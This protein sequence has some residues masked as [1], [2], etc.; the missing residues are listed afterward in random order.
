MSPL[1]GRVLILQALPI[2]QAAL[3]NEHEILSAFLANSYQWSSK[4]GTTETKTILEPA[5]RAV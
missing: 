1:K 5:Q 3:L 4:L 2:H